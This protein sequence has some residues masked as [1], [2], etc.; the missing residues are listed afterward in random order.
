MLLFHINYLVS[1]DIIYVYEKDIA[2][3][4]NNYFIEK[5]N[6]VRLFIDQLRGNVLCIC[7][8]KQ[9]TISFPWIHT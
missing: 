1:F 3:F 7:T 9:M 2:H 4:L 6:L 8:K 5:L